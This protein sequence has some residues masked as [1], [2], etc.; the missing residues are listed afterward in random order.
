MSTPKKSKKPVSSQIIIISSKELPPSSDESSTVDIGM[1][2][3]ISGTGKTRNPLG[4]MDVRDIPI[5]IVDDLHKSD[6]D[7]TVMYQ[8]TPSASFV[9]NP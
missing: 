1:D 9:F 8:T 4:D 7:D 6:S 3:I 5:E 2:E